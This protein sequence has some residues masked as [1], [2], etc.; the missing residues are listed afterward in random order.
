MFYKEKFKFHL[1]QSFLCQGG[2]DPPRPHCD[3]E[4]DP[5]A[6]GLGGSVPVAGDLPLHPGLLRPLLLAVSQTLQSQLCQEET[7]SRTGE[8]I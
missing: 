1:S 8:D 3:E 4:E 7:V 5:G 6:E 2:D